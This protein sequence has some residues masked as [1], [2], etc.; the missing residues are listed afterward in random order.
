MP[1]RN[2]HVILIAGLISAI[3]LAISERVRRVVVV[4]DAL[5]LIDRY[6]IEPVD[7]QRLVEAA[8]GGMTSGLDPYSEFIPASNF[9]AFNDTFQQEFAGVGILVEQPVRGQPARVITPLVG[10]PALEAGVLPGDEI[11]GV[12]GEDVSSLD[13]GEVTE[14]IRGPIGTEVLILM[15]R[16]VADV[17][18]RIEIRL[19][20]RSIQVESVVGDHRADDN[21]WVHRVRDQPRIAYLRVTTFGEKTASELRQVLADA[22]GKIDGLILDVRGNSGGLLNSAVEICDAFIDNGKIVSIRKRGGVVEAEFVATPSVALAAE[23]P[24][25]VLIDGN[26]ASASE[27]VAACLQDHRRATVVGTRSFGKGTV[28]SVL[29]LEAG[30]SALKLTTARYYRPSGLNIHRLA[31]SEEDDDWGVR[32][33]AGQEVEMTD[34]QRR[35]LVQKWQLANYP[36]SSYPEAST[37]P[38]E[39][40]E[41]TRKP[42]AAS[43]EDPEGRMIDPQLKRAIDV[44]MGTVPAEEPV[45]LEP[46][47]A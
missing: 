17:P 29:L 35:A 31:D 28:Q 47:A 19:K 42:P 3:C 6:Y 36:V 24:M 13:I 37:E 1:S 33:D 11:V 16:T 39:G 46:V 10:S 32:P 8:M 5:A 21:G 18:E 41:P 14:R 23:I 30:R 27:I 15:R 12:A 45:S 34:D 4:G 22:A 26:S 9:S 7:Q 25:V 43:A 20:R 38:I 2:V 44:L 40:A